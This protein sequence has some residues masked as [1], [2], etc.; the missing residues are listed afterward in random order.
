MPVNIP[1][2]RHEDDRDAS[3]VAPSWLSK[4]TR[5]IY[6]AN[7]TDLNGKAAAAAAAWCF[8]LIHVDVKLMELRS[9]EKIQKKNCLM[10]N[11]KDKWFTDKRIK[12]CSQPCFRFLKA[13]LLHR[14]CLLQLPLGSNLAGTQTQDSKQTKQWTLFSERSAELAANE[15]AE[16]GLSPLPDAGVKHLPAGDGGHKGRVQNH[17][18][19][20]IRIYL[21]M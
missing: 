1:D 12:I 9:V 16:E 5:Q 3:Y 15:K 2:E 19:I 11:Q 21:Y 20:M 4:I 10:W 14:G 18:V 17:R 13:K 7:F 8:G 6:S